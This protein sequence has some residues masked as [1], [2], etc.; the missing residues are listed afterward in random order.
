MQV[1][2]E[3]DSLLDLH[4]IVGEYQLEKGDRLRL[5]V[6]LNLP[7]ARAFN[8]GGVEHIFSP[9]MPEGVRLIDVRGQGNYKVLFDMEVTG[10][11]LSDILWDISK[12]WSV[13]TLPIVFG[14]WIGEWIFDKLVVFVKLLLVKVGEA[15]KSITLALI[16]GSVVVVGAIIATN[17]RRA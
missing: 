11:R 2:A 16:V 8:L 12:Y 5:E 17:R 15:V 14:T 7:I 1:L 3:G 4:S 10:T 9:V 6:D 13:L